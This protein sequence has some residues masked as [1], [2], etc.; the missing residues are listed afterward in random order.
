MTSDANWHADPDVLAAY[1]AGGLGRATAAS[2]E[3][4]LLG[5]AS[6]RAELV[7]LVPA[8]RV[9]RNLALIH[10]RIDAPPSSLAERVLRGLGVPDRIR[11]LLVVAPSARL[12]W[13]IATAGAVI[14]ALVAADV[15]GGSQRE[16][17]AFLVGAPLVPLGVVTITFAASSDP[18][19][20][21][22]VATPT[23]AFDLL[24]VRALAVLAPA[25]AGTVLASLAVPGQGFEGALWLLPS[26]GLASVA[27]AL[28]SW[29]PVRAVSCGLGAAWVAAALLSVRSSPGTTIVERYVAFR[30]AGQVAMVSVALVAAVVVV[31]RRDAFDLV[32]VRRMS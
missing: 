18:A 27:L 25:A 30:P 10:T 14:G 8:E 2:I 4:H 24:L 32:D 31:V 15:S 17:F 7:A 5:C 12:A 19:R 29:L 16:M 26:V 20:E 3:A 6:C 9:S 11:R 1:A 21:V 13:L 23:P 22:V 28:S